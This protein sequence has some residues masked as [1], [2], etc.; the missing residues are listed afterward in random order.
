[1]YFFKVPCVS[2]AYDVMK[3]PTELNDS[4]SN[5]G[6]DLCETSIGSLKR[7]PNIQRYERTFKPLL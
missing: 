2:D 1:M 5:R 6:Y 3:Q 4:M 7:L